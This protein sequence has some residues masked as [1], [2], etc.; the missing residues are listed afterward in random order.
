M[1]ERGYRGRTIQPTDYSF[2]VLNDY[3]RK[4]DKKYMV[5]HR[6]LMHELLEEKGEISVLDWLI[7]GT[8]YSKAAEEEVAFQAYYMAHLLD[9]TKVGTNGDM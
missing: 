9:H 5:M 7:L 8:H 4:E 3:A 2:H 6:K 1:Y